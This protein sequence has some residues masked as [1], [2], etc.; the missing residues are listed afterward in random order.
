ML[1]KSRPLHTATV[2][3]P[4]N[5]RFLA[6]NHGPISF[7]KETY[8]GGK[9][10]PTR[11]T[12]I[13][14]LAAGWAGAPYK[15][16]QKGVRTSKLS[17]MVAGNAMRFY[18]FEKVANNSEKGPRCDDITFE[19]RAGDTLNFWI[20]EKR[21]EEVKRGLP[22]E[23]TRIEAFTVCEILIASRNSAATE[24]NSGCK[25]ANVK[26]CSFTLY[27]CMA[28]VEGFPSNY[29]DA[30]ELA[31]KNQ[32]AQTAI[33]ADL[34]TNES[35]FHVQCSP[36]AYIHDDEDPEAGMITLVN[37]GVE[38]IDIPV[39]TLLKY[40]NCTRKDQACSLLEMAIA[41]RS[42]GLLVFTNDFWKTATASQ[43][44]AV[45]II[46]TELLLQSVDKI[47]EKTTFPV[48]GSVVVEDVTYSIQ[49]HIDE[50]TKCNFFSVCIV[51][52]IT[53]HVYRSQSRSPTAPRHR[54]RTLSWRPPRSSSS[55]HTRSASPYAPP[56]ATR[57]P[58]TGWATSTA[59]RA[60]A[61]R[62]SGFAS[63]RSPRPARTTNDRNTCLMNH[64]R[65]V[66]KLAKGCLG[67]LYDF[68]LLN[69]RG[70]FLDYC[71]HIYT[72]CDKVARPV[73]EPNALL[74]E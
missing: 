15:Q 12:L 71:M 58:A 56:T 17:E 70:L 33:S 29:V 30:R 53:L 26:P 11:I 41:S 67:R 34:M 24:K 35:V 8:K 5:A 47:G 23:L 20:D 68:Q 64:D 54:R 42:L 50:V 59:R 2:D 44:R 51:H 61:S 27:S 74:H 39:Q 48:D 55:A 19:L 38:P 18:S 1:S 57:S 13:R 3:S 36:K 28:D 52:P 32:Q 4:K 7:E 65:A 21:L 40:T 43:L 16:G 22:E 73:A 25:I 49:L 46:N 60:R 31:L 69:Y 10:I 66:K 72:Q 9:K 14:P 63:A 62:P 37:T 45:P 6:I